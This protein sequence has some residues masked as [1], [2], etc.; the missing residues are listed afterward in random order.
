M[1]KSIIVLA[2]ALAAPILAIAD[3]MTN[4]QKE[5]ISTTIDL[6]KGQE[7]WLDKLT[8]TPRVLQV[9]DTN[10]VASLGL[11]YVFKAKPLL[12]DL[13]SEAVIGQ[14]IP[15]TKQLAIELEVSGLY[16]A[17][18]EAN[19]S[20]LI[21]LSSR[22]SWL[23]IGELGPVSTVY[24]KTAFGAAYS[25]E[26]GDGA[27]ES[28][29]ELSQ[30]LGKFFPGLN[31][32]LVLSRVALAN[33]S[34]KV[35]SARKAVIGAELRDYKRWEAEIVLIVPVMQG[36]LEKIEVSH[37]EFR[38]VSAPVAV[39]SAGLD[40]FKLS[41]VYFGLDKGWFVAFSRG[42]VPADRKGS[43]VLQL[44]WSTNIE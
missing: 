33:V 28:K 15:T 38:E 14:G 2:G 17:K 42:G 34:P 10:S 26:Q 27:S 6:A 22:G 23:W 31:H 3:E 32:T 8:I 36:L 16:A 9:S 21:D 30:G 35:D 19:Q 5:V 24:S 40:R 11:G 43:K 29:W 25:R 39:R 1:K 4:A 18:V 37:R 12:R 13:T 41:S 7:A 44:G 20:K